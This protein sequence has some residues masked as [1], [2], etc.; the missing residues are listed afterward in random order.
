VLS[1][2]AALLPA[3]GEDG[4]DGGDG[5]DGED[6]LI[7]PFAKFSR[8]VIRGLCASGLK[9]LKLHFKSLSTHIIAPA[10][11]NSPQ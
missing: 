8:F 6:L 9:I 3:L 5:S 1:P 4:E 2:L 7:P 10:L 11:S